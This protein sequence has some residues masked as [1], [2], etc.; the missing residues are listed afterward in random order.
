MAVCLMG[1]PLCSYLDECST[2]LD[3]MSRRA[4]VNMISCHEDSTIIFTTHSMNEAEVLCKKVAIL[5]K[6]ELKEYGTIKE[7][8]DKYHPS[9]FLEVF[10]DA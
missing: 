6:G 8:K 9:Y 7:L 2:G 4:M 3:P 10:Y 1:Q 5:I